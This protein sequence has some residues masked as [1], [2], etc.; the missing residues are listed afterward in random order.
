MYRTCVKTPCHQETSWL[1]NFFHYTYILVYPVICDNVKERGWEAL[2]EYYE[3]WQGA[4]SVSAQ[5]WIIIKLVLG[6]ATLM[7]PIQFH[8]ICHHQFHIFVLSEVKD[9]F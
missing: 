6:P 9:C 2:A 5:R 3:Y 4:G 7:S 8:V 1:N